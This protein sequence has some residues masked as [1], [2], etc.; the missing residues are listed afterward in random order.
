MKVIRGSLSTDDLK[1][2]I[3]LTE[4]QTNFYY[5]HAPPILSKVS[6]SVLRGVPIPSILPF[7]GYCWACLN[8]KEHKVKYPVIH[9]NEVNV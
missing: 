8:Y 6:G 7:V 5:H 4:S 9:L 1:M 2:I 3:K